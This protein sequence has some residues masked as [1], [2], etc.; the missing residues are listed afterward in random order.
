MCVR[1]LGV[2]LYLEGSLGW[3][4]EILPE[5]VGSR[6]VAGC[7]NTRT[8]VCVPEAALGTEGV[9]EAAPLRTHLAR[10]RGTRAP[11]LGRGG[12]GGAGRERGAPGARTR[13]SI[14]TLSFAFSPRRGFYGG[15]SAGVGAEEGTR[16]PRGSDRGA[17][18]RR[19]RSS[20]L[21]ARPPR[22]RPA[23]S[24][25]PHPTRSRAASLGEAA[26]RTPPRAGSSPARLGGQGTP[27]AATPAAPA[28]PERPG[29][30]QSAQTASKAVLFGQ[31][32]KGE[33]MGTEGRMWGRRGGAGLAA[34]GCQLPPFG[35]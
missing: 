26:T 3:V 29:V 28:L 19:P 13:G 17:G 24:P 21:P 22:R 4:G 20:P 31:C 9:G 18:P 32:Q 12:E 34:V 27:P 14:A 25:P 11:S 8:P 5:F 10:A 15:G 35:F 1:D 6:E 2:R 33:K 16:E 30:L 23:G 7:V